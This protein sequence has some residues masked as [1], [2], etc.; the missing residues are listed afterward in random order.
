MSG[1]RRVLKW[2]VPVDYAVHPI[3]NGKVVHVGC[4]T[5]PGSVQV[6]TEETSPSVT[7]PVTVFGTGDP[8]PSTAQHVGSAIAEPFVWHVYEVRE[9]P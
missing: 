2:S 8:I 3:G 4:Q 9:R 5:G 1:A 7:R 6:W